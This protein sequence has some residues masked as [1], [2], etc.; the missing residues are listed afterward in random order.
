ML[1]F[2]GSPIVMVCRYLTLTSLFLFTYIAQAAIDLSALEQFDSHSVPIRFKASAYDQ[3]SGIATWKAN[4]VNNSGASISGPFYL[5]IISVSPLTDNV[6]PLNYDDL[7]TSGT[8]VFI[9][10]DDELLSNEV[11]VLSY[12][13]D[14]MTLEGRGLRKYRIQYRL[15]RSIAVQNQPPQVN[16][17]T[18]TT[19]EDTATS[20]ILTAVNPENDSL[21]YT[22]T[23]QPA[24]GAL[25]G[26]P[27]NLIYTP[28]ENFNG[29]DT[30]EYVISDE[31][32]LT[33]TAQVVITIDPV[34][35]APVAND[36]NATTSV[37]EP[38]T[39]SVTSNDTDID[40][41]IDVSTV[42]LD[43]TTPGQQINVSTTEGDWA[44][45]TTT[46]NLTFTPAVDF[47]G[48]ATL[49]YMVLDNEG[50]VSNTATITIDVESVLVMDVPEAFSPNG[51]GVNDFF[52]IE[53]IE[54]LEN[55]EMR[56]LNR[57]GNIVFESDNY[58]NDWD[59]T[60]TEGVRVG[61]EELPVG[62]YFNILEAEDSDG[63]E[64]IEKGFIYLTR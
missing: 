4:L 32:G 45:D 28:D 47:E 52:V 55:R 30:L 49:P 60:A 27:P 2:I 5:E 58:E 15:Y 36:D 16:N 50:L 34:N 23:Q 46:G 41:T 33:D 7:S 17:Q 61:G 51:D 35:D 48:V 3:T 31:E 13:F 57:W 12:Q 11:K 24:N 8:P 39:L 44:V 53:G 10:D 26:N 43:P 38:V 21:S 63:E 19:N 42:D 56:I 1:K 20:I 37:D 62:T 6:V 29:T 14:N 18:I 40:G 22:V 25:T 59:G 64:V 9:I 54:N